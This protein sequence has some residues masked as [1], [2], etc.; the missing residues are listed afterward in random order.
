MRDAFRGNLAEALVRL[1]RVEHERGDLDGAVTHLERALDLASGRED[2]QA[3]H[4]VLARWRKERELGA[5]DWTEGSDRF[6]LSFDTDRRDLLHRSHEVLEHLELSYGD[7]ERWFQ[8]DPFEDGQV[9]RVVLYEPGDFDRLTGL[10]DWAAGVFDGVV[11]VSVED[12]DRGRW[13]S[14]LVHELVHAFLQALAPGAPGWLNEGLAQLLENRPEDV[15]RARERVLRRDLFP[16]EQLTGTLASWDDTAAIARAYAQSLVLVADLRQRFGA[17]AL[18]RMVV[19]I[20]QGR[21]PAESFEAWT[22][23]PLALAFQDWS[24][25]LPR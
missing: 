1:A 9:I 19:G 15:E 16:L 18:R 10:G 11:R 6:Q 20:G 3:M 21:T 5:D 13:R 7:L 23:V 14:V 17:E 22:S 8:T 12:L 2:S 25:S 24:L 4:L